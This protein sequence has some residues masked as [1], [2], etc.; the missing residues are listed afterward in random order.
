[1]SPAVPILDLNTDSDSG[2]DGRLTDGHVIW[3]L[4]NSMLADVER[5][6]HQLVC[7]IA[8]L[9]ELIGSRIPS[10]SQQMGTLPSERTRGEFLGA[11]KP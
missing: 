2:R 7:A 8:A 1:M 10:H 9:F 5:T 3:L 4:L 6:A 11:H